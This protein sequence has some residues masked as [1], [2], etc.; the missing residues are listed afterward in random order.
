[1]FTKT[2]EYLLSFE[3]GPPL[4]NYQIT[5]IALVSSKNYYRRPRI[6]PVATQGWDT[7]GWNQDGGRFGGGLEVNF[8]V[9]E[10]PPCIQAQLEYLNDFHNLLW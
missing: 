5:F 9:G 2:S 3:R 6:I 8:W 10:L 1:M 4:G 7:T